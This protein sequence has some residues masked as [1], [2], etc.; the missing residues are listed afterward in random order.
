MDINDLAISFALIMTSSDETTTGGCERFVSALRELEE[1]AINLHREAEGRQ[2]KLQAKRLIEAI[3]GVSSFAT[4][5]LEK[6]QEQEWI[7]R[8]F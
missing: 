1:S 8:N 7:E 5:H 6:L 2:A 3:M 4:P